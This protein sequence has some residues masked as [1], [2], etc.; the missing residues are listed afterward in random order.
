M[1]P[2]YIPTKD[3][4]FATWLLNFST[5]L[6]ADPTDYGLTAGDATAVAA[7]NTAFQAAYAAAVNPSTRTPVTITAKDNARASATFV[8]RPYAQQIRL[9]NGVSDAL[10]IGIGLN[11]VNNSRPPIPAP[12]TFPNIEFAEASPMRIVLRYSDPSIPD[13]K[14][15]PVGS[16]GL[17]LWQSIGLVPSVDPAQASYS[18]TYTK[19]P[20]A[21][22]FTAG[23]V[24]KIVTFWGR[25]INKSGPGGKASVGPWSPPATFTVM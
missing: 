6:T 13:G 8:V 25:W 17:E 20:L 5:L 2:P 24:G 15:K 1:A 22:D 9:N 3:A 7:Q 19:A 4:D 21:V 11:L 10:K 12:T 18:A 16:I 23:D 14:A